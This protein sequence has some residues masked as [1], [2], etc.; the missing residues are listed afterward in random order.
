MNIKKLAR[1]LAE[2]ATPR[3]FTETKTLPR[4]IIEL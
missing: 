4:P 3:E 2:K 1:E